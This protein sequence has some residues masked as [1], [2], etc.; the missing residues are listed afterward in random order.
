MILKGSQRSGARQLAAHLLNERD[1]D[2]VSVLELR[3]FVASDL[4]G[5]L[6][7]A[8]AVSK[9]TQCKQFMFSLS[10]NPPKEAVASEVDFRRA[11]DA[12]EERLGLSG[13][14]RAIIIHEKEGRRHAHVVWS[15][16][17]AAKLKAVNLSHYKRKLTSLSKELY[18]EHGWTLPDGLRQNG[19]R[20]PLSFS[21]VEWQQ[22]KRQGL[23]PREIKD[24]FQQAWAQSDNAKAFAAALEDRGYF[25]AEGDRRGFVA[26][27]VDGEVYSVPRYLTAKTKE[28]REKLAG[29]DLPSVDQTRARINML[30][31]DKLREFWA[32]ARDAQRA[33]LRPLSARLEEVRAEHRA[34][35][36]R[37]TANQQSRWQREAQLRSDRLRKGLAGLWDKFSGKA[38]ATRMQNEAEAYDGLRRDQKQRD[39]LVIDQMA[40]RRILQERIDKMRLRHV[41][42]RRDLNRKMIARMRAPSPDHDLS[43]RRK[44]GFSLDL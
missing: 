41:Q 14:P 26:L 38:N 12:A 21:L 43:P 44:R 25:L 22:A 28:V 11:A 13:Q 7:E 19:G 15:R 27:D 40:E 23:D 20:S 37:L 5:A 6:D 35:R 32:Q 36:A 29:H 10:L 3:G 39:Q 18:L 1:N 33:E 42:E 16:I 2:H 34:Q 9:G 8:H 31:T 17:D 4:H 30:V 24:A